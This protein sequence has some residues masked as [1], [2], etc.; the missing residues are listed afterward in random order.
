[1]FHI[2]VVDDD[3]STRLYMKA[4]LTQAHY[5]VTL[6]ENGQEALEVMEKE[7]IDLVVLD[8]MMPKMDGYQFT[9]ELRSGNSTLPILMVTAKQLPADRKL[10]YRLG[11]N[12]FMTKPVDE[13]ELLIRIQ[14]LL[15]M[16]QIASEREVRFGNLLLKYDEFSVTKGEET[17]E[18]PQKEFLLL[19]KLLSNPGK[20]SP[21]ST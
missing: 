20:S 14:N 4:L 19:F 12:D 6:A 21:A 1:M 2:M 10:G 7:H 8:V 3:K 5:T 11:T 13:E 16:A 15:R 9:E 17:M 18:L